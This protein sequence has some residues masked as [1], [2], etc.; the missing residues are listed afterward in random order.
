MTAILQRRARR[1]LVD[2]RARGC[3]RR[4][5]RIVAPLPR[6]EPRGA[7]PVGAR[8][9]LR[10][11]GGLDGVEHERVPPCGAAARRRRWRSRAAARVAR[12]GRPRRDA[13]PRRGSA[14]GAPSEPPRTR[15]LTFSGQDCEPGGVARRTPVAFPRRATASRA[16]GSSS[17]RRTRPRS[18]RPGPLPRFSPDGSSVLFVRAEGAP[19]DVRIASASW[20]A[21]PQADRRR[22]LADWFPDG[23]TDRLP[24]PRGQRPRRRRAQASP[25]RRSA[26]ARERPRADPVHPKATRRSTCACRRTAGRSA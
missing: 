9:R 25:R 13:S 16:S 3:R 26:R 10:A 18:H 12:G 11:R 22:L 14:G 24:A 2:D 21:S 6:E 23:T 20:A 17:G 1:E 19:A 8:P 4:S 7:L 5:T 15:A